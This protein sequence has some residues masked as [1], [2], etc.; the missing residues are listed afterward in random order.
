[1]SLQCETA[2]ISFLPYLDLTGLVAVCGVAV[3]V[4]GCGCVCVYVFVW[5]VV[6]QTSLMILCSVWA[7]SP[8]T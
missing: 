2:V 6:V 7:N 3:A 1:M 5:L 4:C 8:S